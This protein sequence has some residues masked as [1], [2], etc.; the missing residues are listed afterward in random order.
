MVMVA[1]NVFIA[2]VQYIRRGQFNRR[3][4]I[5][6]AASAVPLTYLGA[7]F[8]VSVPSTPLRRGFACFLVVL[9]MYY[10][11]RTLRTPNVQTSA[12]LTPAP[13][14]WAI[15]VG[16]GGGFLSG[17]FSV[18]GAVFAVPIMALLFCLAQSAAQGLGLAMVAPGTLV[19]LVAYVRAGDIVWPL[20]I[21]LAVGGVFFVRNGVALA[22][23]LPERTL[24]MLFASLLIFSAPG[25]FAKS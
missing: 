11:V 23:R 2:L 3:I 1:P 5:A 21:P 18:G 19:G 20:A 13:W 25:L 10:V 14:P 22:H 6:L 15:A 24:R 16:A 4:A 8:A 12:S 7:H 9:A 17:I